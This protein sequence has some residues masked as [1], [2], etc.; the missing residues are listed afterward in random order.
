MNILVLTSIG[1]AVSDLNTTFAENFDDNIT[2]KIADS[3][4]ANF[5]PGTTEAEVSNNGYNNK[6]SIR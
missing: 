3:C 6:C 4:G 2:Q 1:D 5:Y